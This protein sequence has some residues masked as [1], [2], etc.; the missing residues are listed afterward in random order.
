MDY[1]G[2]LYCVLCSPF[3]NACVHSGFHNKTKKLY[4]LYLKKSR[5][6]AA[7][8]DQLEFD[9]PTLNFYNL[10]SAMFVSYC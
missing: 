3:C 7:F 1:R 9:F 2:E 10:S 8:T 6:P 4:G 5:H